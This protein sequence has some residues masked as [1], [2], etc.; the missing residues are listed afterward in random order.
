[1][2]PSHPSCSVL[3]YMYSVYWRGTTHSHRLVKERHKRKEQHINAILFV[4]FSVSESLDR[5]QSIGT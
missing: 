3:K 5:R 1:M 2:P 4:R